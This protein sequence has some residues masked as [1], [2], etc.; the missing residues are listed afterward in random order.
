MSEI[1]AFDREATSDLKRIAEML[2]EDVSYKRQRL[3]DNVIQNPPPVPFQPSQVPNPSAPPVFRGTGANAIRP[4]P[5][6][7]TPNAR[8][9]QP[10]SSGRKHCPPL[11]QSEIALLSKH[12]G[13]R[14]CRKFY[15]SHRGNDCPNDFPDGNNYV[16]LSEDVA[17]DAMCKCA[18][19]STYS[20]PPPDHSHN[21]V[22]TSTPQL[23][24]SSFSNAYNGYFAP[25]AISYSTPA[26]SVIDNAPSHVEELPSGP[27]DNFPNVN[28]PIG[29][30]LL[31]SSYQFV[32]SGDS[33]SGG[34]S[35]DVSPLS[36]PH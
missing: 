29:A 8:I 23:P 22:M 16:P 19:A 1:V 13:C 2:R 7:A 6:S 28:A 34:S 14:K 36:C 11:T 12:K 18:I 35:E 4:P 26:P 27:P 21:T 33:D 25:P 9:T 5:F 3:D 15:V 30:I 10:S 31:S 24:S 20:G 32:L 17:Y